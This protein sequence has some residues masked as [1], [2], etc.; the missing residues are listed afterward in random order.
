MNNE[1]FYRGVLSELHKQAE[2]QPK[3]KSLLSNPY[4]WGGLGL[5]GLGAAGAYKYFH[6]QP[7]TPTPAVPTAEPAPNLTTPIA[8]PV[9]T[10]KPAPTTPPMNGYEKASLGLGAAGS[11]RFLPYLRK[12]P[13]IGPVANLAFSGSMLADA[14]NPESNES[15]LTRLTQA[16]A[17]A[18]DGASAAISSKLVAPHTA[19]VLPK[20][21]MQGAGK[22][23]G[24]P[25]SLAYMGG[26]LGRSVIEGATESAKSNTDTLSAVTDLTRKKVP[27]PTSP[28]YIEDMQSMYNLFNTE[29]GDK[30][31]KQVTDPNLFARLGYGQYYHLPKWMTLFGGKGYDQGPATDTVT[32][33]LSNTRQMFENAMDARNIRIP[34]TQYELNNRLYDTRNGINH[35][36][37]ITAP[38]TG[39]KF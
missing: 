25:L 36:N 28:T 18:A 3:K 19:K 22:L 39:R 14:A 6:N 4:L 31:T 23:A 24:G 34:L 20:F 12:L 15:N 38:I 11:T 5:A 26:D 35:V 8:S 27:V 17:G 21:V 30:V 16:G 7:V 13:G 1:M 29:Q 33:H 9:P 37:T 32:K 2:L 10:P